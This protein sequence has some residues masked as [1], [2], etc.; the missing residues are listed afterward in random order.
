MP[1][2]LGSSVLLLPLGLR[3]RRAGLL[4]LPALGFLLLYSLLPHKELRF[5]IYSFPLLNLLAARGGS[6]MWVLLPPDWTSVC[7]GGGV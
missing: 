3:D 1:R 7:V 2:A 6:Y 4:A 5:I